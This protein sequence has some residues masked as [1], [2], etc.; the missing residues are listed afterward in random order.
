MVHLHTCPCGHRWE[1]AADARDTATEDSLICPVCG[2]RTPSTS[3]DVHDG[4]D[5]LPP[6]PRPLKAPPAPLAGDESPPNIA[7]FEVLNEVG[8]GGMG[9]VYKVRQLS[10][11]RVV[12]LKMLLPG[13]FTGPESLARF[14]AE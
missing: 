10:L 12:A 4:A 2:A 9:V 7:G 11:K 14:R 1:S 3:P 8:R 5:Q 13:S 6:P